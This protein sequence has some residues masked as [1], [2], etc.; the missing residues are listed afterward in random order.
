MT[1][2]LHGT[3]RVGVPLKIM[4]LAVIYQLVIFCASQ[5]AK[6]SLSGLPMERAQI[7]KKLR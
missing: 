6:H 3:V 7:I 1:M 5:I 4:T 2:L